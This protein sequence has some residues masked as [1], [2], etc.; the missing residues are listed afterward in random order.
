[1]TSTNTTYCEGSERS[2]D[3]MASDIGAKP[4][5]PDSNSNSGRI[6]SKKRKYIYHAS[7]EE[8]TLDDPWYALKYEEIIL[9][10]NDMFDK[11]TRSLQKYTSNNQS[12]QELILSAQEAKKM[13]NIKQFC[14]AVLGE[15]GVGKSSLIN[16]LFDRDL[17]NSSGSSQACTAQAT[18]LV[19]K[20]G[21]SDHTRLSDVKIEFLYEDDIKKCIYEQVQRWAEAKSGPNREQQDGNEIEDGAD[22]S[23]TEETPSTYVPSTTQSSGNMSESKQRAASTAKEFFQIVF[24]THEDASRSTWLEQ[25]LHT[26]DIR[27]GDF[28]DLCC[29]EVQQRLSQIGKQ[30]GVRDGVAEFLDISDRDL[31]DKQDL[32]MKLWPFVKLITIATGHVLLRH[33]VCLFDL[34]GYGDTSNLRKAIINVFRR[35]SNFE[36]VVV[37]SLRVATSITHHDYLD[38]SLHL[39]GPKKTMVVMNKA[40][41]L[42]KQN[43]MYRQCKQIAEKPFPTL[44]AR[45]DHIRQ[46]EYDDSED[47][48]VIAGMIDAFIKDF[49]IA[50]IKRETELLRSLL[51]EKGHIAIFAVSADVYMTW[52]DFLRREDPFLSPQGSGIPALRRFLFGLPATQNFLD[53][54]AYIFEKLPAF[55]TKAGCVAKKHQEDKSYADMR[56]GVK[57][58]LLVLK[59][60]LVELQITQIEALVIS[61]W[62]LREQDNI[63]HGIRLMVAH[64]WI[65]AK[66]HYSGFAKMLRENGIPD[67]GKYAGKK[68]LNDDVLG[69]MKHY[70]TQWHT[71]MLSR[72]AQLAQSLNRPTQDLLRKI[73]SR[74]NGSSAVPALKIRAAHALVDASRRIE[75]AYLVLLDELKDTLTVNYLKFTTEID[76]HCPVAMEMKPVYERAQNVG[77]GAG[78]YERQRGNIEQ[79]FTLDYRRPNTKPFC[80]LAENLNTNIVNGQ[81]ELWKECCHT[82]TTEAMAQLEAFSTTTEQ[83]VIDEMYMTEEHKKAR[84][85]LR[86]SLVDFDRTLNN[87]QG[88]FTDDVQEPPEKKAKRDDGEEGSPSSATQTAVVPTR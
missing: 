25:I 60:E 73:N 64:E 86:L 45:L 44:F 34:P 38:L 54:R 30:L 80:P 67:C 40:D 13:P 66:I 62:N 72:L 59:A 81:K 57:D 88:R 51:Q 7:A 70:M 55:R 53:Y 83:L 58:H 3:T 65:P 32:A 10:V 20:E 71:K 74:I 41:L 77:T 9:M 31:V 43:N 85:Q 76:I 2:S 79:S 15:Q 1:M 36:I 27:K 6:R 4:L 16:A 87:I 69:T 17:L 23:T 63:S 18:M 26:T 21:A 33:G 56:Q 78:V 75:A 82:F 24:N 14:V 19:Y 35:R 11:L 22:K 46:L 29:Q 42:I 68:N 37:P 50:Y 49:S 61:P 12:L 47:P 52:K 84:E 39:K 8:Q 5:E 48:D 28:A